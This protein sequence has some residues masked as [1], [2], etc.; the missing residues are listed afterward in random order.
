MRIRR[1]PQASSSAP[2]VTAGAVRAVRDFLA[3]QAARRPGPVEQAGRRRREPVAVKPVTVEKCPEQARRVDEQ[4]PSVSLRL[5]NLD[6]GRGEPR[7][8][9][10]PVRLCRHHHDAVA[11]AEALGQITADAAGQF[12]V[13][14]VELDDMGLLPTGETTTSMRHSLTPRHA[15]AS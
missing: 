7:D 5:V 15:A 1:P 11:G 9:R 6:A 8:E 2:A 3:R 14:R 10:V 12:A 13:C 4:Q